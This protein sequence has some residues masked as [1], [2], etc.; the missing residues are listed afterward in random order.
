MVAPKLEELSNQH[1]GVTFLKVD[2]DESEVRGLCRASQRMRWLDHWLWIACVIPC[3]AMQTLL[4]V[5]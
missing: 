3:G 4:I 5:A 1:T 2:V